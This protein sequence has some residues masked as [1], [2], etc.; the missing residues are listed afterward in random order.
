ME[1]SLIVAD[2]TPVQFCVI[3]GTSEPASGSLSVFL[4]PEG[5]IPYTEA[6]VISESAGHP[7][8]EDIGVMKVRVIGLKP[9]MEFFFQ[10]KTIAKDDDSIS[11]S[12]LRG[13]RTERSSAI[14]RNDV[15][16]QRVSIG[17][18]KT[19]AG[20]IVLASVD[21]ASYP[22]S[23]WV[24]HGVP[25]E[26]A[27]IDTNNFYH[28][29]TRV[30]LELEGGEIIN[31]KLFGG[32]MGSVDTEDIV[33]QE[34]GGIQPINVTSNLPDSSSDPIPPPQE[35]TVGGGG[36]STVV[37]PTPGDASAGGG[38]SGAGSSGSGGCAMSSSDGNVTGVFLALIFVFA[39]GW[40][41]KLRLKSRPGGTGC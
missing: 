20:M 25:I 36:D 19:A 10:T 34:K 2:V 41:A 40:L 9:D 12:P 11:L 31:L 8:A 33:P 3:W 14:V 29:E 28:R 18:N 35:D 13:V 38:S 1:D 15:L 30:N 21:Q 16:A 23:A 6:L 4:D 37:T 26:W 39:G 17:E 24:G 27:A 22:V 7:P 5:T 32:S